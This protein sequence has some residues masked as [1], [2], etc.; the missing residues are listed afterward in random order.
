[1]PT[2]IALHRTYMYDISSPTVTNYPIFIYASVTLYEFTHVY[3][4]GSQFFVNYTICI[5]MS[6]VL[7]ESTDTPRHQHNALLDQNNPAF[8]PMEGLAIGDGWIDPINMVRRVSQVCLHVCRFFLHTHAS[9]SAT[10]GLI[11]SIWCVGVCIHVCRVS[12]VS[13]YTYTCAS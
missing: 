3:C 12:K 8:I 7:Y 9:K 10:V 6:D 1:M 4:T 2:C 13:V 11:P 5:W